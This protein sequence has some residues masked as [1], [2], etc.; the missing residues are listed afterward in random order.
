MKRKKNPFDN[1][2]MNACLDFLR[3]MGT[4]EFRIGY[5]DEE[6]GDPVAWYAVV[7]LS[8]K[9]GGRSEA[10]G[11]LDPQTALVRLIERCVDGGTCQHCGRPTAFSADPVAHP[12]EDASAPLFCWYRFDPELE[13]IRRSCEG[14]T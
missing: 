11:A 10:E 4:K 7:T 2:L 1:P 14:Q 3:R 5:S 8:D 12:I 6:D 13:T 9:L